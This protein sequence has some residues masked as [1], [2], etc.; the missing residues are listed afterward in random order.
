MSGEKGGLHLALAMEQAGGFLGV[1]GT[2]NRPIA[3]I[4]SGR[5]PE[6]MNGYADVDGVIAK[7]VRSA[8]STLY[9]EWADAPARFFHIHGDPPFECFQISVQAPEGGL[10]AVTARAIDTN[11]D[12]DE[13]TFRPYTGHVP[14]DSTQLLL[15]A[16]TATLNDGTMFPAFVTPAHTA[17]DFGTLQPHMFVG[18]ES[19]GFWGGVVGIPDKRRRE[20]LDACGKDERDVF[21]VRF[22]AEPELSTGVT[23]T[24]VAG[25]P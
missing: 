25:W 15:V 12:T 14:A 11:D 3:D 13:E 8:D 18:G 1:F 16:A 23:D 9:T 5:H 20:F 4:R 10:T 22:S 21:P 17:G 6:P 2:R 24:E 19:Y 7:W